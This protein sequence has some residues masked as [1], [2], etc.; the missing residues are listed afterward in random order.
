M[1]KKGLV[2]AYDTEQK[3]YIVP[4]AGA[5]RIYIDQELYELE[6]TRDDMADLATE[7]L[8]RRIEMKVEV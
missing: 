5:I 7:I 8:A 2:M 3:V 1:K 6:M 4:I